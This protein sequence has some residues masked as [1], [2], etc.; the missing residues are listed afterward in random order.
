M[1]A[2]IAISVARASSAECQSN[3][4][5]NPVLRATPFLDQQREV[6]KN[7]GKHTQRQPGVE[8]DTEESC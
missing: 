7:R 1:P 4:D 5:E 8:R 3:V 6:F 2:R